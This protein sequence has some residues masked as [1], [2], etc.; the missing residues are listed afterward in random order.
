[1]GDI[2]DQATEYAATGHPEFD[3]EQVMRYTYNAD[4][5][6]VIAGGTAGNQCGIAWLKSE[7]Y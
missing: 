7:F 3:S 6:V 1:M 4:A 5:L 2:L